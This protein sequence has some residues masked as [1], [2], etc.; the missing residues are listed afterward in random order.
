MTPSWS[1]QQRLHQAS[2]LARQGDLAAAVACLEATPAS[3]RPMVQPLLGDLL[4]ALGRFEEALAIRREQAAAEPS[5]VVAQHNLASLLG[6]LGR[7]AE[8]AEAAGRAIANGGRAP[9]TW[10]VMARALTASSRHDE[11][12]Q[13]FRTALAARPAYVEA[14]RELAQLIWMR[15]GDRQATHEPV[16]AALASAPDDPAL[17]ECLAIVLKY[18][19]VAPMEAWRQLTGRAA[20]AGVRAGAVELAA[21]QLAL[22]FDPQLAVRH[23][24]AATQLSPQSL[25]A[26]TGLA[27]AL[28]AAGA[29]D[30]AL[31]LLAQLCAAP[32]PDQKALAL[33]STVMRLTGQPDALGLG[34][35]DNLVGAS[36]IDRPEGW[37]S[38]GAYLTDLAVALN[39]QHAYANH[40]LGQSLRHGSQTPVDLLLVDDPVIR[41]FFSCIDGPI[42]RYL[43]ALGQGDDPVRRRNTGGYRLN[44]CW[45]VRLS[46]GG[47]HEPHV[48]QKGWLSSACYIDV[49]PVVEAGGR[50]GWLGLGAPPFATRPLL[51]PAR[52][53][54][55]EPG[56]LVLFPSCMWHGTL[57]F[58]G[59]QPRL[60]V[61]FD[62]VPA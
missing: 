37:A 16:L 59:D 11:A 9:E 13:A 50:E 32:A 39:A 24:Q 14:V 53:E 55:P 58:S 10:L 52:Y 22:D 18:T 56:K 44:G 31:E 60:T 35:F 21:S 17:L 40:P 46:P 41:A 26:W 1:V 33:Y 7:N 23:A 43:K 3:D 20:Q 4:K 8:A 30:Q 2:L 62:I 42:R 6:D 51:G 54:K 57:P 19:G 28:T 29:L 15:G 61:A 36:R 34:D 38:L 25:S 5:S 45:S 49:P 12:V 47:F 48:H 27:Q